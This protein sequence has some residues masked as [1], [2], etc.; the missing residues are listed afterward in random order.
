MGGVSSDD[1]IGRALL[2]AVQE[3]VVPDPVGLDPL[4][5]GVGGQLH[6]RVGLLDPLGA[7]AR[8]A[9]AQ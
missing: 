2:E 4:V 1:G 3:H 6:A 5:L 9:G 8:S 7:A